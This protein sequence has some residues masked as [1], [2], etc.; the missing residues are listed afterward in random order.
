MST[1]SVRS[2]SLEGPPMAICWMP[3]TLNGRCMAGFL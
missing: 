3:S 1:H 2:L